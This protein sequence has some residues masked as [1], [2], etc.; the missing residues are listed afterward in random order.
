MNQKKPDNIGDEI[1]FNDLFN[2]IKGSALQFAGNL[3]GKLLALQIAYGPYGDQ[4]YGSYGNINDCQC[5]SAIDLYNHSQN[6]SRMEMPQIDSMIGGYYGRF[7]ADCE[8]AGLL[9]WE[10]VFDFGHALNWT[11]R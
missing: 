6:G 10:C 8:R 4:L 9:I 7:N 11:D 2:Q 5:H 1:G 3:S